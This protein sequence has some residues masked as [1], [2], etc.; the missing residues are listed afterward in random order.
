M[1]VSSRKLYKNIAIAID[2]ELS[3]NLNSLAEPPRLKVIPWGLMCERALQPQQ[4]TTI[5]RCEVDSI[6]SM[7]NGVERVKA[8]YAVNK[9]LIPEPKEELEKL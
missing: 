1:F 9:R 8:V 7:L 5:L 4:V 3:R 6:G 2:H